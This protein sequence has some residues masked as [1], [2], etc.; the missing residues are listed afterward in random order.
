[1]KVGLQEGCEFDGMPHRCFSKIE[2]VGNVK[3]ELQ[4]SGEV[5]GKIS[6][7]GNIRL[8]GDAGKLRSRTGALL[9]K[10]A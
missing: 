10:S 7:S 1:M 6:G 8:M 4:A 3:L 5:S 2:Y 9:R